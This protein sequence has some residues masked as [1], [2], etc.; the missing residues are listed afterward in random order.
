MTTKK[1]FTKIRKWEFP[2]EG[3]DN[4]ELIHSTIDQSDF[5]WKEET[6]YWTEYVYKWKA[7]LSFEDPKEV[8]V[9][10]HI[11]ENKKAMWKIIIWDTECVIYKFVND[12]WVN[13]TFNYNDKWI[14]FEKRRN[15][16]DDLY[17]KIKLSRK[18]EVPEK[19]VIEEEI[20]F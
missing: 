10:L 3:G 14:K 12:Y 15:K 7:I 19:E 2:V 13:P 4:Y 8:D 20:E 5:V 1:E 9:E 16:N 6:Q 17:Y 11:N 18:K